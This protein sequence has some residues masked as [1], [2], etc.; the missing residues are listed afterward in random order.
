MIYRPQTNALYS[1][2]GLVEGV[3]DR[4]LWSYRTRGFDGGDFGRNKLIHSI[5]LNGTIN[6][7]GSV[8][9]YVDNVLVLTTTITIITHPTTVYLPP[10]SIG[11]VWSVELKD[12]SGAV[13]YISTEYEVL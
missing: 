11:D 5:E 4:N 9:I 3:S 2:R 13:E 7:T 6:S 1:R 8:K 12:W 10:N